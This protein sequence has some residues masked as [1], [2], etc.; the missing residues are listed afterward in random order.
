MVALIRGGNDTLVDPVAVTLD[1][2][3]FGGTG[4]DVLRSEARDFNV[5][6][7]GSGDDTV[8]GASAGFGGIVVFAPAKHA[9]VVDLR[10]G[11]ANGQGHDVLRRIGSVYGT[12]QADVLWGNGAANDF[13]GRA[14]DDIIK[15]KGG[16]DSLIG[17]AGADH[18]DGGPGNDYLMGF[19][20]TDTLLG[21]GGDDVLN[22][23]RARQANLLL[24]GPG[25]DSCIG[26]YQVPPNVERGCEHHDRPTGVH[27]QLANFRAVLTAIGGAAASEG[28]K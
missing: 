27:T 10:R 18:L 1:V 14:G 23:R 17:K 4:N 5:L 8:I 26:G 16:S 11:I 19:K 21:R 3:F 24:A 6:I 2:V 13:V 12:A 22:E 15:A 20:G 7:P 28:T 9:V 25:E